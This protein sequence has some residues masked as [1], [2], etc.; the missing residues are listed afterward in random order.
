[1]T[2]PALALLE[3]DRVLEWVAGRTASPLAR[4]ALLARRPLADFEAAERELGRVADTM[5]FVAE[6]AEWGPPAAPSVDEVLRRLTVRKSTLE[7]AE[8]H[9]L[10]R[11]L[12]AG[13]SVLE[14]FARRSDVPPALKRLGERL[15]ELPELETRIDRSVDAEGEVLDSASPE[16]AR[17]RATL[18]GAHQR[19]VR[20]LEAFIGTLDDRIRVP[21]ASVSVREGRYVIPVRREGRGRVGGIVHD[22]SGTGATIFV[23]PPIGVE[24]M[25]EVRDLEREERREIGRILGALSDALR[26]HAQALGGSL[27]A[28]VDLDTLVA[29]ARVALEWEATPPTFEDHDG[30]V[31]V[32]RGRHPLLLIQVERSGEGEVVPFDLTLEAGERTLIVSGPNTGGKSVFLKAFGLFVLLA[33][34]GVVPPVGPGTRLPRARAVHVDIGDE[35]SIAESLSTFSAHLARLTTIVEEADRGT[36]VLIDELGTGTDPEEGAAL[37]RA[38]LETLTHR[39]ARTIATSHLGALKTLDAEGSGIVNASL[40]FDSERLSPTYRLVKGRPGRSYGLAIAR[41]RGMPEVVIDRAEALVAEGAASL[42]D[43]LER[44]E[45]RER[46]AEERVS[47]LEGERTHLTRLREEVE[48]REAALRARERSEEA[49]AREEARRLLMDARDEVEAAIAELREAGTVLPDE[50]V[51]VARQRVEEAASREHERAMRA[52]SDPDEDAVRDSAARVEVGARV[53]VGTTGTTGHVVEIRDTRVA[54][55]VGGLRIEAPATDLTL[56]APAGADEGEGDRSG[57]A[58]RG[59]KGG[60]SG[61]AGMAAHRDLADRGAYEIDLRGQRVHEVDLALARALDAAVLADLHEVRIIHGK[62]TGAVKA[63]VQELLDEDARVESFRD[64]VAG[65]GGSG[66]TLAV[67]R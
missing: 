11:L 3:F 23:E 56:L 62:G 67:F 54:I 24:L 14:S 4:E 52:T 28:L 19:A 33:R 27:E 15:V 7:A 8:V 50:A 55:H 26:P 16:L 65:E 36:L 22:E 64:G 47:E 9:A 45:A 44:L 60:G 66:V 49:R 13:R 2:R 20:R 43:L 48:A 1:M 34:A 40:E 37:A 63:R 31:R 42:E 5:R 6:S 12:A 57:G 18:R 10:G 61:R 53:R 30:T 25:N 17:I 32:T 59:R 46:E 29:R 21:D 58:S 38:I 41:R 35:Q 39:G 51:R